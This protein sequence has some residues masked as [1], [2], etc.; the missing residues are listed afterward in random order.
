MALAGG[1][2]EQLPRAR[3]VRCTT[4]CAHHEGKAP[5]RRTS[6]AGPPRR[7]GNREAGAAEGEASAA[8]GS[9]GEQPSPDLTDPTDS[10][11]VAAAGLAGE[12]TLDPTPALTADTGQYRLA[13]FF[14]GMAE[15][16][17]ELLSR[18]LQAVDLTDLADP[19]PS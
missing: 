3:L 16:D 19:D 7:A 18:Y 14:S 11:L 5:V 6:R 2:G 15:K 10:D 4:R 17:R 9:S 8:S 13:L 1:S 12:L